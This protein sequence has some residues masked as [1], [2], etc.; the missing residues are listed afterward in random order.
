M[1]RQEGGAAMMA[2]AWGKLTGRPGIVMATRGPGAT[3]ASA[4]LHVG[5]QDSTPMILLLGQ[6]GRNMRGREAFQ[7]IDAKHFFGEVAKSVEEIDSADRIPEIFSR[8]MH[9]ATAGRPGPVV[10]SLPEDMLRETATVADAAP[11]VE[12]ETHPGPAQMAELQRMLVA[13]EEAVRHPRRLALERGGGRGHPALR[14]TIRSAGRLL[15]SPSDALRSRSSEL[16]RRR[17]DRHQPGARR[18]REGG[19]RAAP[20]RRAH[21]RDAVGGLHADRHS[22]PAAEA[23]PC[24]SRAR[25]NL[26]A[27]I[28]RRSR[29]MP[30][31]PPSSRR[32]KALE[33]PRRRDPWAAEDPRRQRGLPRLV[34]AE[35]ESRP[36]A[37]RSDRHLAAR[38]PARRRDRHQ[39][40][41]QLYRLGASLLPLPPLQHAA[42]AA[43]RLDGLRH[44][45]RRSPRSS[46]TRSGWSSPSPATAAF[47]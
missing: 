15:A 13:G 7:E 22:E 12:V 39:R 3:N 6:V 17:R 38:A 33:P 32:S 10:L 16:R 1:A 21:E 36:G 37:A 24:L 29:S 35:V 5:R 46:A 11:W 19:G 42:C 30:R 43:L 34:D 25:R 27:S 26:A 8:A 20:D 2:E 47:S 41:R 14:R 40:R 9:M 28:V 18:A 31:R 4:G 45:R 23:D 44:C